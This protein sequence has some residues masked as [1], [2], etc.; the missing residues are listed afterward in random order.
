MKK[1]FICLGNNIAPPKPSNGVASPPKS[2][3]GA[4]VI[5]CV[6]Y[7]KNCLLKFLTLNAI[8]FNAALNG[9]TNSVENANL[10]ASP[11]IEPI[12]PTNFDRPTVSARP[13][14]PKIARSNKNF[15]LNSFNLSIFPSDVSLM[16]DKVLSVNQPAASTNKNSPNLL[17]I[18]LAKPATL[19]T[20]ASRAVCIFL[21]NSDSFPSLNPCSANIASLFCFAASLC[22]SN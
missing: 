17:K 13:I 22:L 19:L 10:S 15:L 3:R 7:L 18:P 16:N 9:A 4:F 6:A 5:N 20:G 11:A 14:P 1:F 21:S 8:K 12:T 2:F